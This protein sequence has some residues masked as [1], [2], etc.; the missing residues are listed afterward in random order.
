MINE[1]RQQDQIDF[2]I[3]R[4]DYEPHTYMGI[5][6]KEGNTYIYQNSQ[7]IPTTRSKQSSDPTF[8]SNSKV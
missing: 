2:I 3:I 5:L 6:I 1:K 7:L 4:L 8:N